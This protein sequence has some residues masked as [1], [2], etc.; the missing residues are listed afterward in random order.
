[1]IGEK[2]AAMLMEN[3]EDFLIPAERV[4]NVG[5]RNSL[6]HALL[7]LTNIGYTVIP[8]LDDDSKVRGILSIP[9]IIRAVTGIESFDFDQLQEI[10]VEEVMTTEFPVLK[11]DFSLE[12]ALH[13]LVEHAFV[14]V[15]DKEGVFLGIV[16]RSEL[17]KGTNRVAHTFENVYKVTEKEDAFPTK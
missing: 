9:S 5:I 15:T 11:E 4:A 6:E 1:M 12:N 13:L 16:T 7:V 8:V 14:C 2:I 17:L 10:K 3:R